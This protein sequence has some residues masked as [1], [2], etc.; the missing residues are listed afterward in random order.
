MS[1][2]VYKL[3]DTSLV[4][5]ASISHAQGRPFAKLLDHP[6]TKECQRSMTSLPSGVFHNL[7]SS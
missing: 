5:L 6:L 2:T 3:F 4:I 1:L 7:A